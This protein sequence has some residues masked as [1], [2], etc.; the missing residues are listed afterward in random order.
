MNL[1]PYNTGH[2]M[3][4]PNHHASTP[5][6]VSPQTLSEMASLLPRVTNA[7]RR[8]LGCD[9]FNV[10]LNIGSVAGAGIAA[11]MHQHVVPRWLG[12]ANFMPILAHT[13]TM[14]ELLPVTYAKLRC[15]LVR[16]LTGLQTVSI[17][18]LSP[19]D[20]LVLLYHEVFPTVSL[21]GDSP[22]VPS[23]GRHLLAAVDTWAL[24]GWAGDISTATP[25]PN[26]LTF[27]VSPK[28]PLPDGWSLVPVNRLPEDLA[29]RVRRALANRAPDAASIPVQPDQEGL[30]R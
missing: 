18:A 19:D 11:H 8:G 13:M 10:G 26:M 29:T 24:T 22:A 5:E 3:I 15:E 17:I 21:Q 14:P 2:V 23:I 16:S 1:F 30:T 9:G 20:T 4:I 7:A 25:G 12:D 6:D 27:A 28:T